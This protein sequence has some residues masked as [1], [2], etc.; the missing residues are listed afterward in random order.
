M[1]DNWF[2][3]ISNHNQFDTYCHV[4][5]LFICYDGVR[6]L[7][8]PHHLS[9]WPSD[10]KG[11]T[12]SPAY[13]RIG[14]I[15]LRCQSQLTGLNCLWSAKHEL[16]VHWG[17]YRKTGAKVLRRI[18]EYGE[19]WKKKLSTFLIIIYIYYF[20]KASDETIILKQKWVRSDDK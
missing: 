8:T 14:Y 6:L 13:P 4:L 19:K 9:A 3:Y 15:T 16:R 12:L 7:N 1:S 10:L 18:Y 17:D 11:P 5:I 2:Q 20:W